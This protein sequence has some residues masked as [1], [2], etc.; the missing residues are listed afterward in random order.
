MIRTRDVQVALPAHGARVLKSLPLTLKPAF[1]PVSNVP[2]TADLCPCK[3]HHLRRQEDGWGMQ[4]FV[5]LLFDYRPFFFF[6][7][8]RWEETKCK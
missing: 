2:S 8:S 7:K 1:Q 4:I 3:S 5:F 6:L